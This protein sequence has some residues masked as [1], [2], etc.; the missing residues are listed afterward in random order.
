MAYFRQNSS[1]R[2]VICAPCGELNTVLAVLRILQQ[3]CNYKMLKKS[4]AQACASTLPCFYLHELNCKIVRVAPVNL[5][6]SRFTTCI[7]VNETHFSCK[8][9]KNYQ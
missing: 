8:F 5:T 9:N 6:V 2:I 1:C 3:S 4:D 7:Q